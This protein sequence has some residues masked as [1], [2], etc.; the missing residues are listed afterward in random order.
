MPK[1]EIVH[2]A[3][4]PVTD[5]IKEIVDKYFE[6]KEIEKL[7]RLGGRILISISSPY[8]RK[9][10]RKP[11]VN[12]QFVK[13]LISKKSNTDI[14]LEMLDDLSS[15]QLKEICKMIKQPVKSNSTIE[16]LKKEIIRNIQ[17][18]SMWESISENKAT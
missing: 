7:E 18:E 10:Q 4:Q 11:V 5:E 15:K 13:S 2:K 12:K 17:A 16:S 14:L 9:S 8:R 3:G 1:H 6:A